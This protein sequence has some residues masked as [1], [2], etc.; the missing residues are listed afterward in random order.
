MKV[1]AFPFLAVLSIILFP[2]VA[3][4]QTG[5]ITA[6][7]VIIREFHTEKERLMK[8]LDKGAAFTDLRR[9]SALNRDKASSDLK[10]LN[11]TEAPG[12]KRSEKVYRVVD[13][14]TDKEISSVK[15]I[16]K[17]V[18]ADD[19]GVAEDAVRKLSAF[20][21]AKLGELNESIKSETPEVQRIRPVPVIDRTPK[22]SSPDEE[23]GIWFR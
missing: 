4:A 10:T 14:Y 9:Q 21:S 16:I 13:S 7:L 6:A 19:R 2:F 20:R 8:G 3:A 18:R 22:G 5:S 1:K 11:W 17:S 23:H 15:G 12:P